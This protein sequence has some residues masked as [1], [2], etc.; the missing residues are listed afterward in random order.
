M[1]PGTPPPPGFR[2]SASEDWEYFTEGANNILFR[3]VGEHPYFKR[4]LLRL[5]KLLPGAPTTRMLFDHINRRFAPL[6]G[7]YIMRCDLI[8]L[9]PDLVPALNRVLML[10]DTTDWA[11][12]PVAPGDGGRRLLD[13]REQWGMLVEDMS[14]GNYLYNDGQSSAGG[15]DGDGDEEEEDMEWRDMATVEFKPKWLTQSPNAPANWTLCRTCAVRIMNGIK[16]KG[17]LRRRYGLEEVW[18]MENRRR[19]GSREP[20]L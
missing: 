11:G 1:D 20:S 13:E 14:C 18:S 12:R 4:F 17:H 7:S 9:E 8:E 19:E 3:Y 16:R 10:Q 6:L 5:R 15:E 2:L